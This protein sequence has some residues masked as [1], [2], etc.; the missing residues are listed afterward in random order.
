[1][2]KLKIGNGGSMQVPAPKLVP[3]G[4]KPEVRRP[5]PRSK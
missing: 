3:G 4:K 2:A 1:M 5:D